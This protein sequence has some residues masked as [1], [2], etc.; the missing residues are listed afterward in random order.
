VKR[1]GHDSA[2][3]AEILDQKF[4]ARCSE[5]MTGSTTDWAQESFELARDK[6]YNPGQQTSDGRGNRAYKLSPRYQA[7]ALAAAGKKCQQVSG[8]RCKGTR[9]AAGGHPATALPFRLLYVETRRW[10][11]RCSTG[12]ISCDPTLQHSSQIW[13]GREHPRPNRAIPAQPVV[14]WQ[15]RHGCL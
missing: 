4:A 2:A 6:A 1:L 12:V 13:Q 14:R 5:W 3:V 10:P 11:D 15:D 8:W 9:Q 7:Q